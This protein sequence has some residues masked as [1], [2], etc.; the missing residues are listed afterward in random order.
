MVL[1]CSRCLG[2]HA[3]PRISFSQ[4]LRGRRKAQVRLTPTPI[5]LSL[6]GKQLLSAFAE[7]FTM[8][9]QTRIESI[10]IASFLTTRSRNSELWFV[11]NKPLEQAI[12]GYAAK[13][14][15]RYDVKLYALAV[16]GNHIQAPALFPL[17]NRSAFM[18]DWNSSIA[19]AVPR[20]TSEYP[21]G[22][23]WERR[24]SGEFLPA[25]D[26]IE[27]YFF[28]TVLQP[29]KDG[30]VEKLSE[31]PGYN[32]FYDAVRGIERKYKVVRWADYNEARRFNSNVA[33]K[34]FV[35]IIPLKFERLP[36]YEELS[37]K[38]YTRLMEEKL[39]S[40][41]LKIVLERQKKGLGFAGRTTLMKTRRGSRPKNT[42]KSTSSSHR[43]RILSVCHK[44]RAQYK[45][46]YFGIISAY[47]DASM[48]YRAG[49]LD[50]VFPKGTYRPPVK[51]HPPPRV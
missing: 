33:F 39:E 18:R 29:V 36:G 2:G 37:Q 1:F 19:R 51:Y 8:G 24:Y 12:L 40:R 43:P 17:E 28:Y 38:A 14:A 44:R 5:P 47:K 21:G 20:Y 15:R 42:K 48:R 45:A 16:E 32:C 9:Y 22:R 46:W 25:A 10:E 4:R 6:H 49:E 23:F 26:D 34:D 13:Y 27:E 11:N 35:D 41:R 31:Y 50:V 7:Q 30:L 3:D